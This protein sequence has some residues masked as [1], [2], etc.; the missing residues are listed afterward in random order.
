MQIDIVNKIADDLSHEHIVHYDLCVQ[1]LNRKLET[2]RSAVDTIIQDDCDNTKSFLDSAPFLVRRKNKARYTVWEQHLIST[3]SEL[4]S[5][6]RNQFDP[7]FLLLVRLSSEKVDEIL[8]QALSEETPDIVRAVRDIRSAL[9][10]IDSQIPAH[11]TVFRDDSFI[12]AD[13]SAI[14]HSN[15]LSTKLFQDGTTDVLLDTTTYPNAANKEQVKKHV[16]DLTRILM[17][18]SPSTLGLLQCLGVLHINDTPSGA[19]QYQIVY[20]VPPSLHNPQS[21]RS[22]L[23]LPSLSLDSKFAFAKA[24]ARGVATVH[25]AGFVHKNVRP[26]TILVMQDNAQT[27]F[28]TFLVGF[29]NFRAVDAATTHGDDMVWQRNLYRHPGMQGRTSADR[30]LMQHDIYSLGVVLLELG[31]W[32]SFVLRTDPPQTGAMLEITTQLQLGNKRKAAIEIKEKLVGLAKGQL[33]AQMGTVYTDLVVSC[34][35]CL[36]HGE[37]NTF[38]EEAKLLDKDGILVGV[39]F[40]E[41]VLL[42]LE[43]VSF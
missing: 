27:T 43:S 16:R 13:S 30:Y 10:D 18:A 22:L 3:V 35:T 21:L 11:D 40:I 7:S 1:S 34:L 39:A 42:K 6:Y 2:A 23:L 5:W 12:T 8:D 36:D 15:L 37:N 29:E 24:I 14:P 25:T 38:V 17:R 33:P 41:K 28:S 31:L 4:E 9:Q 20:A 26:E 19:P 32:H